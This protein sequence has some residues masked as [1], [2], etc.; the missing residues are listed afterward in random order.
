MKLGQEG[1]YIIYE[2]FTDRAIHP[3]KQEDTQKS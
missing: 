3:I 2:A 1:I